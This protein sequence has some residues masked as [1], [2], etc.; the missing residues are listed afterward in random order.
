[1]NPMLQ[2]LAKERIADMHRAAATDRLGR[3]ATADCAA[4]TEPTRRWRRR[5]Q[6]VSAT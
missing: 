2:M 4:A 1:M 6:P 3:E 5:V